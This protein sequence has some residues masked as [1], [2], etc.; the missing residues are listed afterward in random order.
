[1]KG[2][3]SPLPRLVA[4]WMSAVFAVALVGIAVFMRENSRLS[5]TNGNVLA[6]GDQCAKNDVAPSI[7]DAKDK[8]V[9]YFVGCGGFF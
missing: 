8:D 9:I 6:Q 4:F 5:G 7:S 1:M 3:F 2:I